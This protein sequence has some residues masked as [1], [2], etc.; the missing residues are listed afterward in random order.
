MKKDGILFLMGS[1]A[2]PTIEMLWRGHT[3]AS[4]A[5]AGGVCLLLIDKICC[6]IMKKE[7]LL[8]RCA[9]GSLIITT[10]E[11]AVGMVVNRMLH[12]NVW[13]YSALPLNV[14]GQISLPFS[15]IWCVLTIPATTLC[16]ICG[17]IADALDF[18]GEPDAVTAP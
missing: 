8:A 15:L 5:L 13:D 14:L 17:K 10:V 16:G 6:G 9:A 3:H 12:L 11:F 2:Y 4:M 1:C 7:S 18:S